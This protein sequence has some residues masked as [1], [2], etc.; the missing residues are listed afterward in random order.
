MRQRDAGNRLLLVLLLVGIAAFA[1]GC[2]SG[3]YSSQA[4]VYGYYGNYDP[5]YYGGYVVGMPPPGMPPPGM[6]PPGM[7]PPGVPPPGMR[8]PGQPIPPPVQLPARPMPSP[9]PRPMPSPRMR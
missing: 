1:A 2:S 5:R 7:R 6:P 9:G 8:P 4:S 3:G